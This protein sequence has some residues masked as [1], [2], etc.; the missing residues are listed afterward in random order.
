VAGAQQ[1]LH[2]AD[3]EGVAR[4]PGD[5]GRRAREAHRG[6]AERSL[7]IA[8]DES[9]AVAALENR[10]VRASV[11]VALEHLAKET[12]RTQGR[13]RG[14]EDRLGVRGDLGLGGA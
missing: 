4:E 6:A 12:H 3:A 8:P 5:L 2:H 14:L 10:C 11:E 7:Y 13:A 1:C 9:A